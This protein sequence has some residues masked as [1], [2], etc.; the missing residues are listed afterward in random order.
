[1]EFLKRHYEKLILLALSVISIIT[2]LH[3]MSIV[4]RTKEVKDSDLKIPTRSPDYEA[5]DP[6][7]SDF[8]AAQ[9]FGDTALVWR[10]SQSRLKDEESNN[11]FSDLVRVFK[12]ARCPHCGKIVPFYY[13]SGKNCPECGNELKTPVNTGRRRIRTISEDDSDGDGISDEDEKR[14][15]LNQDDPA[16]A[17]FDADG[18]GFS[19]AYEVENNF[20][21]RLPNNCPPLWYRLRV[22]GVDRVELPIRLTSVDTGGKSDPAGW[23]ALIKL[24]RR[25]SAGKL[26]WSDSSY[27]IGDQLNLGDRIY[28]VEKI[29]VGGKES[30][31][32]G[33]APEASTVLLREVLDDSGA[34]SVKPEELLLVEGKPVY[35]PD[36]RII[37]EDIGVPADEK[38]QR[39]VYALRVGD[40]FNIGGIPG[41]KGAR[42]VAVQTFRLVKYDE[43]KQIAILEDVRSRAA[44]PSLDKQGRQMA[45]TTASEI[46]EDMWV[47]APSAENGSAAVGRKPEAGGGSVSDDVPSG[48]KAAPV[49]RSG[50]SSRRRR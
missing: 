7:S 5:H 40:R 10:E 12:M 38:G 15:G 13:F 35:S 48:N 49:K 22:R 45:V 17:L 19:N 28:R 31:D 33:N 36:S 43:K 42:A 8:N 18:N 44:D 29:T 26:V 2:V 3:L 23:D 37:L 39:T 41:T 24:Q 14:Y 11:Y 1:M 27:S 32:G 16:D 34:A 50:R 4:D 6:E 25:N 9:L 21:P 20:D 47:N 46:P 30:R